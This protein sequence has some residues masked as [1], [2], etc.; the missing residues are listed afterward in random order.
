MAEGPEQTTTAPS[1][2]RAKDPAQP[3]ERAAHDDQ[4]S[5][6]HTLTIGS[7]TLRYTATTGRVVLRQESKDEAG[8]FTGFQPKAEI[9]VTS[10]VVAPRKGQ[11][12]PVVFAF[13][14]GPGSSSVWLHLG[15]LGPRRV[16]SGDVG[17]LTPPPYALVDNPETLLAVADLVFIDP[18]STGFSRPVDGEKAADFHG[19]TADLESVGEVIRLWTTR[20]NR[21]LSP[22]FLAGESYGTTRAAALA[23]YLQ[24]TY[25]LTLNGLILLSCA[26]DYGTLDFDFHNDRACAGFLPTYAATAHYHGLH[27]R[28]T[29]R[30]VLAQAREY[31]E[32][33]YLL[34]LSRGHRLP[35][36]QRR[37]H[38]ERIAGLIGVSADW[39]ERA[40]LRI[41]HQR[42]YTE[43][44]RAQGLVV[45]RLDTRF[46]GP[47]SMGSPEVAGEDPS[48]SAIS[49][50]YS[51][52]WNHYVRAELEYESDVPYTQLSFA[53]NAE[54][55]FKEF[56][57]KPIDVTG[58]LAEVIRSNPHL[59]VHVAY[60]YYDGATPFAGVEDSLAHL[61]VPSTA[62]IEEAYYEAGHMMYVHEPSRLQQ[63]ADLAAFIT[64]TSA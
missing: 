38:A 33:D 53:A 20:N 1:T 7:R 13:N 56:V 52:A 50:A 24:S 55:S 26:L 11:N 32:G 40:G 16:D 12:R 36:A 25:A 41:E 62:M 46:T 42:Y 47:A 37:A 45:G 57:G 28:R 19:F 59:R 60:G 34:A 51:A 54:W 31:A 8:A 14:G 6:R 4:V 2:K 44:L 64:R 49:G 27:G 29:L 30:S 18:V 43:L 21:W 61:D 39:V 63:S 3:E 17:A 48:Y 9:F 5:T 10:Y 15:L 23:A 22:K 58:Q 35:A